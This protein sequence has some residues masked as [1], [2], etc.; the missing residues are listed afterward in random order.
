M[1]GS[2]LIHVSKREPWWLS[3][4]WHHA[5]QS[6]NIDTSGHNLA[7]MLEIWVNLKKRYLFPVPGRCLDNEVLP[8]WTTPGK[9]TQPRF[10]TLKVAQD[11]SKSYLPFLMSSGHRKEIRIM[12][13]E[14]PYM[15]SG[16]WKEIRNHGYQRNCTCNQGTER[17]LESWWPEKPYMSSEHWKEI[18]NH[19]NQRNHTCHQGTER[20]LESW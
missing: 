3:F 15:L 11:F 14:K 2:K 9:E 5:I 20:K 8:L 12:N 18:R 6:F 1:L 19:D 17:K 4:I 10:A 13:P 7:P 16:H